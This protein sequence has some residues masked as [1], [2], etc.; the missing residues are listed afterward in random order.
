MLR[1]ALQESEAAY[2]QEQSKVKTEQEKEALRIQQEE[3]KR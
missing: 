1:Q 3:L 2:N